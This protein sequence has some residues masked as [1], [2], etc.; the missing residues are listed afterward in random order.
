PEAGK[1]TVEYLTKNL[2]LPDG[3]KLVITVDGKK[4]D[5]G[6]VGTG[7]KLSLVYK[8]ESA[9]TRDYYLLIYGDPSGDGRINSFD[10]MQLTRYI[11]ELDNPTEI[12]R[13]AMDVTKDGQVNSIDMM[14]VIQHIL[15]MDSIE[16]AK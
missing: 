14:W 6:I 16:Q 2:K 12:E 3:Y 4:V 8:N 13:Q 11:L 15:E 5:S 9:S 7:T 1:N 10:T